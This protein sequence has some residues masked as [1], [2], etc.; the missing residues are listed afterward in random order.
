MCDELTRT[1]ISV[2]LCHWEGGDRESGIK[3][4]LG[5]MEG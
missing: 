1:A 5:S 2:P 3:S 4:S